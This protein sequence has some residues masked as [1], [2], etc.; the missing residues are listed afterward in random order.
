MELL[1]FSRMIDD[2][3]AVDVLPDTAEG[4][5][6]APDRGK[7]RY[8]AEARATRLSGDE[9]CVPMGDDSGVS[10]GGGRFVR[11]FVLW[12]FSGV[13]RDVED[14][15]E[16]F[17]SAGPVFSGAEASIGLVS[18]MTAIGSSKVKPGLPGSF[19]IFASFGNG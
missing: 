16:F 19:F 18:S 4:E 3:T 8:K 5:A 6:C 1:L 14:S 9:F 15:G 7:F 13:I 17:S 11:F 12:D 2:A 10:T